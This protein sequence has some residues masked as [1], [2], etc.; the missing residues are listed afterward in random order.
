MEKFK[1]VQCPKCTFVQVT[2]SAKV[3]ACKNC[4]RSTSLDRVKQEGCYYVS[5]SNPLVASKLCI[6]AKYHFKG[7]FK[8]KIKKFVRKGENV[9][10]IE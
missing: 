8:V 3:L 6:N 10:K 4:G 1:I 5:T 7:K 2:S 9:R